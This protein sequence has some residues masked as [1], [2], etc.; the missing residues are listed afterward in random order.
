MKTSERLERH[1][2]TKGQEVLL[3]G[4]HEINIELVLIAIADSKDGR[5]TEIQ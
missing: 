4:L 1:S 2:K 3:G 5:Q